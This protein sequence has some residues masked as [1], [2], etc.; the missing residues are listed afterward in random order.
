MIIRGVL[1]RGVYV[2]SKA[3][4]MLDDDE[5]SWGVLMNDE[6]CMEGW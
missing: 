2:C 5:W 3:R 1:M 6:G 4:S